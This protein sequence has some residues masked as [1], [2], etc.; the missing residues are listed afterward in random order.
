MV[1][2]T[3]EERISLIE[4]E[5]TRVKHQLTADPGREWLSTFG[6]FADDPL[7]EEIVRNGAEYRQLQQEES[8]P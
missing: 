1:E 4:L 6:A 7:F 2:R 5:L 8:L 3:L